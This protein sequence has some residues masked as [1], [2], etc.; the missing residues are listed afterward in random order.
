MSGDHIEQLLSEWLTDPDDETLAAQVREALAA[1]AEFE[2]TFAGWRMIDLLVRGALTP[3]PV[4][5]GGLPKL[6]PI[7]EPADSGGSDKRL[8][9]RIG[10]ERK[11]DDPRPAPRIVRD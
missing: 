4:G 6:P 5:P 11:S 1:N 8:L 2:E 3:P 7:A 9:G 10:R